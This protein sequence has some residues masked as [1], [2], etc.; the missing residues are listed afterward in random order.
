MSKAL[1]IGSSGTVGSN[2]AQLLKAKGSFIDSRDISAA[3]AELLS[4]HDLDN[5]AFNL[6]GPEAL[7][8]DQVAALISSATNKTITYQ[9]ISPEAML[10]GLLGAGVPEP[11]AQFLLVILDFFK[12]GYSEAVTDDLEKILGRKGISVEEYTK[13]FAQAWK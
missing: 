1:I 9:E 11:Y 7:D 2:L 8:H 4:S 6:T 13:D 5:Q 3:A 10:A 12:Q